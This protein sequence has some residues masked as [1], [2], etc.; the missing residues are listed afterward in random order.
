MEPIMGDRLNGIDV[1]V[2]A[3]EA[4]SFSQASA[5][6]HIT[7]SAVA[8]TIARLEQRLGT[9]LFHRTTRTQSLTEDGQAFYERCGRVLAE[10]DA[11]EAELESGK[12][13]PTGLLRIS[14]P[15][16]FGRYC[17]AP[18]LMELSKAHPKLNLELSFNDRY[19]DLVT[20]GYDLA[21]RLG[22]LPDSSML[23]A[24]LIGVQ[25]MSIC[26][27]PA[28][29]AQHGRP[30]N[31]ADLYQHVGIVYS[32]GG[33][34]TPWKMG[35]EH[36]QIQNIMMNARLR[37]DDLQAI[38]DAAVA[39]M[40]LAW[41]PCWLVTH[42]LQRGELELVFNATQVAPTDV[43]VVW[44][45]TKYLTAKTRLVIDTLVAETPQRMSLSYTCAI[46]N[47]TKPTAFLKLDEQ[48]KLA[49]VSQQ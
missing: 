9:R 16:M 34:Q 14:M 25:G 2:T 23:A 42:Y 11:A 8:K 26:A 22:S 47:N 43:Y 33:V 1:F 44:P 12:H 27:S 13:E 49:I 40:G 7:R 21:V 29:I 4:G 45:K 48:S 24:R 41:L 36:G 19:I 6:L 20:E 31:I 15:V 5:R 10:L 3:V 18:G 17:V 32:L 28:Y 38:A 35:D 46:K 37:F 30:K 39:G